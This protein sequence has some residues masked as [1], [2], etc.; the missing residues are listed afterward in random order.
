M[1]FNDRNNRLK[2]ETVKQINSLKLNKCIIPNNIKYCFYNNIYNVEN[3]IEYNNLRNIDIKILNDMKDHYNN[4]KDLPY[5][6]KN[7]NVHIAAIY[8]KKFKL[9]KTNDYNITYKDGINITSLHAEDSVISKYTKHFISNK[10]NNTLFVIRI[11]SN[12]VISNSKPCNYCYSKII[13]QNGINKV[14][15]SIDEIYCCVQIL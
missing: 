15:Y 14:I 11:N 8:N 7:R 12:G 1:F 6:K 13:S 4:T 9:I 10:Y 3:M 2:K 5:Y